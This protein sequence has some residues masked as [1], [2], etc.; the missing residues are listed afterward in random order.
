MVVHLGTYCSGKHA[1]AAEPRSVPHPAIVMSKARAEAWEKFATDD[2]IY[3]HLQDLAAI[4]AKRHYTGNGKL[5]ETAIFVDY[6]KWKDDGYGGK[7]RMS[8]PLKG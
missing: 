8:S 6:K 4:Y 1:K 3:Q 5:D 7:I 2:E